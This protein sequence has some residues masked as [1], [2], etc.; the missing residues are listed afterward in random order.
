MLKILLIKIEEL[1]NE[2]GWRLAA[3]NWLPAKFR[4]VAHTSV[5]F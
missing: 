3:C 2:R 5:L 1:D 4:L